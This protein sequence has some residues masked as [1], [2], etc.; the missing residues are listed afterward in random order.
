MRIDLLR[1]EGCPSWEGALENLRQ[2]VGDAPITM[3]DITTWEQAQA[4]R[5]CGSPTIRVDGADLFP[6]E[7]AIYGLAC[8]VYET[9]NGASGTPTAEMIRAALKTLAVKK[10]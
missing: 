1:F 10:G 9:P 7:E 6:A 2:V 8:R 4:E 3:I 5:F